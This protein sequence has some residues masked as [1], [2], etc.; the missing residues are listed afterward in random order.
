MRRQIRPA[1]LSVLLF[2][3]AF[4]IAFPLAITAVSQS[5]FRRQASGSLIERGGTI[6][7]SEL[8]GQRFTSPG[9]FHSR[10]SAAGAGYDA[11]ASGATNLGPTSAKLVNGVHGRTASDGAGAGD[12]DGVADLAAAFRSENGL[13]AD[14]EVPA[15]SVTRSGSGLDP[16]ISPSNAEAQVARVARARGLPESAVRGLVARYTSGRQL[17]LLG[18]P[19]VNVLL[20]NLAL[21]REAKLPG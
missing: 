10:P 14:A 2:L 9:Y 16:H 3:A 19:R 17:G 4:G 8:I 21:D 13:P 6:V 11:S 18:E 5:V 20:L 12:F 1:V 7:G 15:D